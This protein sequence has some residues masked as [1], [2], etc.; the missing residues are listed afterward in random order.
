V[1]VQGLSTVSVRGGLLRVAV[2]R[3][4]DAWV[5][6]LVEPPA[7][8]ATT[9][10]SVAGSRDEALAALH[11]SVRGLDDPHVGVRPA[12]PGSSGLCP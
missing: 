3:R 1:H 8:F 5:A 4:G 11:A 10:A 12:R 7:P 2:A 6:R 9:P